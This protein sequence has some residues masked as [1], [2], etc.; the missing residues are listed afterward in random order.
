MSLNTLSRFFFQTPPVPTPRT[1]IWK[2]RAGN[3]YAA[4]AWC[5][6]W[7][8][9]LVRKLQRGHRRFL[10]TG[11]FTEYINVDLLLDIYT[12]CRIRESYRDVFMYIV[13]IYIYVYIAQSINIEYLL[14]MFK[15]LKNDIHNLHTNHITV[16]MI[17]TDW[18]TCGRKVKGFSKEL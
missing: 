5:S 4:R 14:L 13:A 8:R 15:V 3:V 1:H 18:H 11:E 7:W 12:L 6:G 17:L 10:K 9:L 2:V 16:Q